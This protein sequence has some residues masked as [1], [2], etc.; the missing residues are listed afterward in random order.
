MRDYNNGDWKNRQ[1]RSKKKCCCG[2]HN[3]HNTS[4]NM[5]NHSTL[6]RYRHRLG[7]LFKIK[8]H[9][10]MIEGDADYLYSAPPWSSC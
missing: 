4:R 3:A 5:N 9:N 2:A 1:N 7:R 10:K 8:E 6:E